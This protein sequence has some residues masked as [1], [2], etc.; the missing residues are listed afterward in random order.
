MRLCE[1]RGS[2]R[3]QTRN[4]RCCFTSISCIIISSA[5]SRLAGGRLGLALLSASFLSDLKSRIKWG[6]LIGSLFIYVYELIICIFFY[7]VD[8]EYE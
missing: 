8:G 4:V 1:I 5:F 6:L 3:I 7:R 2:W